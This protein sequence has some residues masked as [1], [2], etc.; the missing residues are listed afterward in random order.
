MNAL[1]T[2]VTDAAILVD[3]DTTHNAG[4]LPVKQLSV[5]VPMD[6]IY[7]VVA[8]LQ[9][10]WAGYDSLADM[11][12]PL[13]ILGWLK[14]GS[15]NAPAIIRNEESWY[16]W[17][18]TIQA[19]DHALI[20]TSYNERCEVHV[21]HDEKRVWIAVTLATPSNH[22]ALAFRTAYDAVKPLVVQYKVINEAPVDADKLPEVYPHEGRA[23][24]W[25]APYLKLTHNGQS[26]WARCWYDIVHEHTFF[27]EAHTKTNEFYG[28][29]VPFIPQNDLLVV[30]PA[31]TAMIEAEFAASADDYMHEREALEFARE[32]YA[33]LS[34]FMTVFA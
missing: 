15:A 19:T 26:V 3:I 10:A 6:R 28:P 20:V 9:V 23:W 11:D 5:C 18:A 25:E 34:R 30:S 24:L 22:H 1:A 33:V 31:A 8:A 27:D 16:E 21:T 32:N 2:I 13:L 14:N 4:D 17:P 29:K 12:L 7:P